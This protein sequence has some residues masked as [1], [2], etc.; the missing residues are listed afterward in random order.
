MSTGAGKKAFPIPILQPSFCTHST[1]CPPLTIQRRKTD[2]SHQLHCSDGETEALSSNGQKSRVDSKS[3]QASKE[4]ALY[5]C[6]LQTVSVLAA[7]KPQKFTLWLQFIFRSQF[8][9]QSTH[10]R[11]RAGSQGELA[12]PEWGCSQCSAWTL[13]LFAAGGRSRCRA[14]D[15][16][17]A[18]VPI[19]SPTPGIIPANWW[20]SSVPSSI[21]GHLSGSCTP[22]SSSH[23]A[24][25]CLA[26]SGDR[27]EQGGWELEPGKASIKN[28]PSF[29]GKGMTAT[30]EV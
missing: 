21:T 7:L 16:H 19:Q 26:C 6:A 13:Q 17:T 15:T 12:D 18:A 30:P 3:R 8:C 28:P 25:T 2:K 14:A 23:E 24:L 22:L 1:V 5:I 27:R 11:P 9:G 29:P 20:L 4:P 10:Y